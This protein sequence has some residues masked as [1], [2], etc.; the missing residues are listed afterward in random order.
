M[1]STLTISR[2]WNEFREP[3]SKA[4]GTTIP[5]SSEIRITISTATTNRAKFITRPGQRP[6]LRVS[7]Q[8]G[9]ETHDLRITIIHEMCHYLAHGH[10]FAWQTL[11][12]KAL[13]A[14]GYRNQP[15]TRLH[16][17]YQAADH[18]ELEILPDAVRPI[19]PAR[20]EGWRYFC[21]CPDRTLEKGGY[22]V[23]S[24]R[25]AD[26]RTCSGCRTVLRVARVSY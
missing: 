15:A 1:L 8:F 10:G 11:Y 21:E 3:V 26:G 9:G 18:P 5:K 12:R 6:E 24:R 2:L 25:S 16:P 14:C 19:R 22:G 7:N 13:D 20:K 4:V 17:A 23:R